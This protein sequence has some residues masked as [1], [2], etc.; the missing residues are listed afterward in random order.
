MTGRAMHRGYYI[1]A[2][3]AG[4]T[5]VP[6]H[7]TG[8]GGA[9]VSAV[10]WRTLTAAVSHHDLVEFQPTV[11]HLLGHEAV[12]EALQKAGPVLPVRF[13]TVLNDRQA[14]E[15]A[16]EERCQ[17][18]LADL[19]RVGG[20]VELGLTVLWE[21]D[22]SCGNEPSEGCKG[23][24]SIDGTL[25]VSGPAPMHSSD[26]YGSGQGARYLRARV[27]EHRREAWLR[28]R[29]EV[30]ARD[31]DEMLGR[32]TLE[33]RFTLVPTSGLAFRATYLLE[34]SSVVAFKE[35]FEMVRQLHPGLRFLLSGPWP[36]YSFVTPPTA[37]RTPAAN[38]GV[39]MPSAAKVGPTLTGGVSNEGREE[40]GNGLP[41]QN[42]TLRQRG[43]ENLASTCFEKLEML[44]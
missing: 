28:A 42:G 36:P 18:L 21:Q 5:A 20:K 4:E 35:A 26:Q 34:L 38:P 1:Y 25:G 40:T 31:V 39:L 6:P 23:L 9:P 11:E 29:A 43:H 32:H 17:T 14:V 8:I 33:R 27:A 15:K 30:L 2:V 16:L 3:L 24:E 12:V 37:S 13:G 22:N 41:S 10:P 44:L 7:L 19:A